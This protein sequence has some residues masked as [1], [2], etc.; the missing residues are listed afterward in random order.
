MAWNLWVLGVEEEGAPTLMESLENLEQN[1]L[2]LDGDE[3]MA[4]GP[5]SCS[6]GGY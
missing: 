1:S 2:Q 4:L 5:P 3:E 6:T